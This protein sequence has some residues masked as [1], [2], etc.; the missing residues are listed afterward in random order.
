MTVSS[1]SKAHYG[2]SWFLQAEVLFASYDQNK[3][4]GASNTILVGEG[5]NSDGGHGY[6]IL[7]STKAPWGVLDDSRHGDRSNLL[8]ADGHVESGKRV[9][10]EDQGKYNWSH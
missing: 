5:V 2:L 3:G 6:G 1:G 10:Y 9:K 7:H 4:Y 8:L